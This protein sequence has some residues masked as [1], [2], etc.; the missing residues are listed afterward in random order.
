MSRNMQ[1]SRLHLTAAT[2]DA[3]LATTSQQ[4]NRKI[5]HD[6]MASA[7]CS[8]L[9]P[10]ESGSTTAH[11]TSAGTRYESSEQCSSILMSMQ[12]TNTVSRCS[13]S[14]VNTGPADLNVNYSTNPPTLSTFPATTK[15]HQAGSSYQHTSGALGSSMAQQH[16]TQRR[17]NGITTDRS[18]MHT[19]GIHAR[20]KL[21][22]INAGTSFE[23]SHS[24]LA[25]SALCDF[26]RSVKPEEEPL[27]SAAYE[28]VLISA[29]PDLES[30]ARMQLQG[31]QA[32]V[33]PLALG[34][35]APNSGSGSS[36]SSRGSGQKQPSSGSR[37]ASSGPSFPCPSCIGFISIPYTSIHQF[38]HSEN[39]HS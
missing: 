27:G 5:I 20:Q 14:V 15:P 34:G 4:M 8:N 3:P 32:S 13:E 10:D 11:S 17:G 39:I 28:D 18:S 35:L 2:L 25:S 7:Q 1:A 12:C 16:D 30:T 22:L 19:H 36:S 21:S 9:L 26:L 31:S 6:S 29:P 24:D 33:A 23:P 38:I 37:R